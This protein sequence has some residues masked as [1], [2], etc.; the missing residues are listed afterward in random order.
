MSRA[1]RTFDIA[2][3]SLPFVSTARYDRKSPFRWTTRSPCAAGI[4]PRPY[5]RNDE[6]PFHPYRRCLPPSVCRWSIPWRERTPAPTRDP[7][8]KRPIQFA[9]AGDSAW[10]LQELRKPI[11]LCIGKRLDSCEGIRSR[12]NSQDGDDQNVHEPV[13]NPSKISHR[14]F[15]LRQKRHQGDSGEIY[16]GLVLIIRHC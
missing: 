13:L 5:R 8:E 15:H 1:C 6:T 7:S 14:I 3:I 4:F 9:V 12:Q 11:L 16:L 2:L 10:K